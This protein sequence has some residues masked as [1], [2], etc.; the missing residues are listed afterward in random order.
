MW[1]RGQNLR[2]YLKGNITETNRSIL[3][4]LRWAFYF[5]DEHYISFIEFWENN[6]MVQKIKDSLSNT[7]TNE[8]PIVLI[9][10]RKHTIGA[11]RFLRMHLLQSHDHLNNLKFLDPLFILS[12]TMGW[13]VPTTAEAS[14]IPLDLKILEK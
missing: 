4:D 2:S 11:W 7:I 10:K 9:K 12:V 13:T 1:P 3:G 6:T 8:R 14:V 5:W